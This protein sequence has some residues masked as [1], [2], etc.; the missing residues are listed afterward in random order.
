MATVSTKIFQV[1]F[2]LFWLKSLTRMRTWIRIGLALWIRIRIE[3]K[4]WIRIRIETKIH[5]TVPR[6][7]DK[8]DKKTAEY[9][10]GS[11]LA[12]RPAW[13]PV[14]PQERAGRVPWPAAG[15][16]PG[17]ETPQG[18][19]LC[20]GKPFKVKSLSF[21]EKNIR[22]PTLMQISFLLLKSYFCHCSKMNYWR[23]FS[24]SHSYRYGTSLRYNK[25]KKIELNHCFEK[26]WV[27]NATQFNY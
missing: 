24:L 26:K 6:N 20:G 15:S 4:S 14:L 13:A 10:P 18:R 1:K 11:C 2:P 3:I 8:K 27:V 5:N 23:K 22:L 7:S 21:T 9:I 12:S 16:Y 25:N 19:F 17:E